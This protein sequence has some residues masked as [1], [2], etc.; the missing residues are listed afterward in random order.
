[1]KPV[2]GKYIKKLKT[3]K[4][5]NTPAG[6]Y[7]PEGRSTPAHTRRLI[8]ATRAEKERNRART[9]GRNKW[10]VNRIKVPGQEPE[11]PRVGPTTGGKGTQG[12]A[13]KQETKKMNK[14]TSS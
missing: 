13:K 1:L 8:T 12:T 4:G 11:E 3:P 7:T 5:R 14:Q 9:Q 2:P 6:G 10:P